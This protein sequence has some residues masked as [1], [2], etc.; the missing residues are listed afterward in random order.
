[1]NL[2]LDSHAFRWFVWDDSRLAANAKAA[3]EEPGNHK[4]VSVAACWE[5]AI[6]AGMNKL[7]LGEAAATFLPRELAT[8]RF[9]L[10]NIDLAHVAHV[11]SLPM[12]HRDPFDRLLVSQSKLERMPLVS[13]DVQFDLYGIDRLW[14]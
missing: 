8:N 4:F 6:K 12:H 7:A 1:M 3:I 9:D 2:L 13:A 5:I 10:L 14:E 11:E